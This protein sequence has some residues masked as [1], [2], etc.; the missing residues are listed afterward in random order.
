M[1]NFRSRGIDAVLPSRI[2]TNFLAAST[3]VSAPLMIYLKFSDI[4]LRR[5]AGEKRNKR[6]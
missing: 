5:D 1:V 4:S 6:A 3:T 2:E